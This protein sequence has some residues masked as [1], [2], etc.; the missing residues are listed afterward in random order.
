MTVPVT[1]L[2]LCNLLRLTVYIWS[3][4]LATTRSVL[5]AKLAIQKQSLIKEVCNEKFIQV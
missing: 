4:A 2:F 5:I 3:V 1:P